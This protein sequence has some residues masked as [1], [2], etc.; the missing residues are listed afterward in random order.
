[1][2]RTYSLERAAG[3]RAAAEA[4]GRRVGRPSTID[5]DRLDYAVHLRDVDGLTVAEIAA[6][7]KIPRSSLYRHLP[8]RPAPA[9]TAAPDPSPSEVRTNTDQV[10]V[11]LAADGA[12]APNTTAPEGR[13]DLLESV[14]W[15]VGYAPACPTCG[16]PTTGLADTRARIGRRHV[17][18]TTAQ[19]CGCLADEHAAALQA[20]APRDRLT[21]VTPPR[22]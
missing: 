22:S 20:A 5:P 10:D 8:P 21:S 12:M 9:L 2:E 1:M 3:A 6:K 18:V 19:P 17:I 13:R 15:P 7:T 11:L 4:R 16:A 14:T